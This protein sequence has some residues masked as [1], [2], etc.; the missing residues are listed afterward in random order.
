MT[1]VTCARCQGL[2]LV[3][4][5]CRCRDGGDSFLID[6]TDP[7]A[8]ADRPPW[9][10]CELCRGSGTTAAPCSDCGQRGQRRAQVVLT[11]ANLDTG[12]VASANVVPGAVEPT[13]DRAGRWRLALTPLL[14]EL[15][16]Q[17]GAVELSDLAA[18]ARRLDPADELTVHLPH[19]WRPELPAADRQA[20]EADAIA[21]WSRHPWRVYLGRGGHT[22]PPEPDLAL[23]RLRAVA[24]L[25][26][27]DLVV[28]V[29]RLGP[30][31]AEAWSI[32]YEVPGA[33]V[34]T[35]LGR[36]ADDLLTALATTSVTDALTGLGERSLTA[37]AY[38][39]GAP[40]SGGPPPMVDSAPPVTV[41]QLERRILGDCA[42]LAGAQAIWRDRR[43]QHT[44]L[45]RGGTT[46]ILTELPTG[47]VERRSV[48]ALR[49]NWEPPLPSYL[50]EPIPYTPCRD[51]SGT[52]TRGRGL[53]CFTCGGA[54]RIHHGAV[55]TITDLNGRVVHLNWHP[56]DDRRASLV[57]THAGGNPMFQ[58][59]ERFR[60]GLWSTAFGVR[61]E[62]LTELDGGYV[63][64]QDLRQG[65][66][67][68]SDP[69]ANPVTR[70]LGAASRGRP[71]ARLLVCA[72]PWDAPPL[73]DLAR[74]ALGLGLAVE[75][76]AQ[77][78]R[79]NLGDLRR[80]QGV[81]WE[82]EVVDPATPVDMRN[83]P[84]RQS[85]PE[86]VTY[87]LR[88]LSVALDN[89]VPADP[90][91]PL[92]VPQQPSATVEVPD[93]ERLLLRL[94]AEQPGQPVVARL[95]R[96]GCRTYPA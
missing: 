18:P 66:I 76:A 88:Y 74:L 1:S 30:A 50:G 34:P 28:E 60:V 77:D 63:I 2:A 5:R 13:A 80:I 75:V 59:A 32:R 71:A 64:D 58:L 43:W 82:V 89:A 91:Q 72:R 8:T 73:A 83:P 6:A 69:Y 35:S 40:P 81:W 26:R 11:V 95:D 38:F 3:T 24:D 79:L 61:P 54:R 48:A 65:T 25:L 42:H 27:L 37:P 10:D 31:A 92:P 47:Q 57:A 68:L 39:V 62:E 21:G 7:A 53:H 86:A 70:Y 84:L 55:L 56:D 94:A 41:D 46:T 33:D 96:A 29:R 85:L 14:A 19:E 49:R 36:S 52:G 15:A 4:A 9:P 17:V 20:L 67:T 45:R 93:L 16:D 87:C 78:H 51:C 90:A 44:S 12:V 23:A 22:P